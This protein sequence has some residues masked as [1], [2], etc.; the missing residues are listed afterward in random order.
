MGFLVLLFFSAI[1]I[2]APSVVPAMPAVTAE[3]LDGTSQKGLVKRLTSQELV[4]NVDGQEVTIPRSQL[5]KIELRETESRSD[6]KNPSRTETPDANAEDRELTQEVTLTDGSRIQCRNVQRNAKALTAEGFDGTKFTIPVQWLRSVRLMSGDERFTESWSAFLKRETTKDLLIVPKDDG[7]GLDFLSGVVSSITPDEIVF[8]M[9]NESIPVPAARTYGVI[10]PDVRESETAA[11]EIVVVTRGGDEIGAAGVEIAEGSFRIQAAWG[12][13]VSIAAESLSRLD[14]SA[15]RIRYLSDLEPLKEIFSGID[16]ENSLFA[17]LVD[18]KSLQ[19]MYGP[20][21][22]S[23]LD[24]RVPIR[25]RGRQYSKGLCI[26]SRTEISYALDRRYQSLEAVIGIDDEVAGNQDSA[27]LVTITGDGLSLY[28]QQIRTSDDPQPLKLAVDQIATLTIL[29]DF[30]DGDS[31]C[32]WLDLA[33][34]RLI[35][36]TEK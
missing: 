1:T 27:V 8:L 23:T 13:S 9:D 36:R 18:D 2:E 17:G 19:L 20:R 12:E 7:D 11:R 34:A 4:L 22:N 3:M 26:H 30:G 14:F 28:S 33:D 16:P 10:F 35:L 24:V 25:L 5:M 6:V 32:D 29:V 21:R 31:S 15:G